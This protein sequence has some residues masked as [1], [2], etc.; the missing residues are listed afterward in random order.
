MSPTAHLQ[1]SCLF[2]WLFMLEVLIHVTVVSI[3]INRIKK[4][5]K[6]LQPIQRQRAK[7]VTAILEPT[8]FICWEHL[9][10]GDFFPLCVAWF[11]SLLY[12]IN[13]T[14]KKKLGLGRRL[15]GIRPFGFRGGSVILG[16]TSLATFPESSTLPDTTWLWIP[17]APSTS[18]RSLS[19]LLTSLCF[20][21]LSAPTQWAGYTA[22]L[23]VSESSKWADTHH[24]LHRMPI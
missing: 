11:F 19:R 16:I 17:A 9:F 5:K 13:F 10:R 20:R 22:Y 12:L 24:A 3:N 2:P 7:F 1:S 15:M 4:K 6:V 8:L 23:S 21:F 18:W 14:S